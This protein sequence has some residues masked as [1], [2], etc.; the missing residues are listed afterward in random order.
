MQATVPFGIT[1]MDATIPEGIDFVWNG[2]AINSGPLQ[3]QLD[4]QARAE[5]DNRGELDYGTNVARARFNVR[6]DLSGVAKLL[7]R[8]ARCELIERSRK[9]KGAYRGLSLAHELASVFAS[10]SAS[11]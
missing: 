6:I 9:I 7:A 1:K 2:R 3:V 5:G 4:N 8:A 10:D 11:V